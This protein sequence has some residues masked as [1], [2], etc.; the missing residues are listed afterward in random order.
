MSAGSSRI[1]RSCA[2][3][4]GSGSAERKVEAFLT[5]LAHRGVAAA[6]QNQALNALAFLYREVPGRELGT[7]DALRVRRPATVRTALSLAEVGA[8]L[9]ALEDVGGYPTRLAARLLYGCGLR[10][11]EP[12]ELG[13]R[14]GGGEPLCRLK[15][16]N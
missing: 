6:T 15:S 9:E 3:C 1:L 11:S 2:G 10:V 4:P 14:R 12:L 5:A 7:V 13:R 16:G 8:L